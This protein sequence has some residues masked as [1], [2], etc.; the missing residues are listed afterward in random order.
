MQEEFLKRALELAQQA[1]HQGEVPVGAV[2][3]Y[4]NN[5]IGEGFNQPIS[6]NDPTAHAEIVALRQAAKH[7]KNYRLLDCDIYVTLEP[8][9]MCLATMVH[10]RI[11]NCFF[12]ARDPEGSEQLLNTGLA[13]HFNHHVILSGGFLEHD[14]SAILRNFFKTRR[15]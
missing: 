9:L 1:E 11:K 10:A 12:G 14:C 15:T 13:G 7:L 6:S 5:I 8:C 3:V 4:D 2:I